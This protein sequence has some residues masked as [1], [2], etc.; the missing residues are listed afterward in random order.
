MPRCLNCGRR[1]SQKDRYCPDCGQSASTSRYTM[2]TAFTQGLASVMRFDSGLPHTLGQLFLRPWAVIRDM[3]QGR[4]ASYTPA[5]KLLVILSFVYIVLGELLGTKVQGTFSIE[6]E[7]IDEAGSLLVTTVRLI[8]SSV[9]TQYLL[10]TVPATL[11]S[12]LVF[13]VM[14]KARYNVA[15]YFTATCYFACLFMSLNILALP[16]R[17]LCGPAVSDVCGA[18]VIVYLSLMVLL[19]IRH[20]FALSLWKAVRIFIILAVAVSI[21]AFVMA[22]VCIGSLVA[23]SMRISGK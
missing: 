6:G 17:S 7:S 11:F 3:V 18:V 19:S 2:R 13:G 12:R 14:L 5:V 10:L 4:W 16:L 9:I 22:I 15:E 8:D 1:L 21:G 20:A 23:L